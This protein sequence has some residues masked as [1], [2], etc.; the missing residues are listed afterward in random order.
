[1][2]QSS[3]TISL[4]PEVKGGPFVFW[5]DLEGACRDAAALG[6]AAVEIFLPSPSAISPAVLGQVLS[7]HN[8]ELA[9]LGTG[10]GWAVHKLHLTHPSAEI[11]V[12]AREFIKGMVR[13][14]SEFGAP[15]IVGSMQGRHGDG[16]SSE[17]ARSWLREAL[18]ELGKEAEA[19]SVFLLFEPLNRY[20]T[21]LLTQT[22]DAVQLL[23]SL[24]SPNVKILCDLFHMNIEE[25]NIGRSLRVAGENLGHV[26]W[27]DSNR[28][29]AGFGHLD[30]REVAEALREMN[31]SGYLSA[32]ALPYP[33]S[34]AAAIRSLATLRTSFPEAQG[35][36]LARAPGTR[37]RTGVV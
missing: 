34:R 7:R 21:N 3:V 23:A 28:R 11:R 14:G 36:G 9:A 25:E 24:E 2:I 33:D 1:M 15:A 19:A 10:A 26:H 5:D 20:E 18:D 13:F 30:F 17:Q 27:V 4:V 22:A 6:Y 8:L 12:R 32:E 37:G 16:V 29:A 35:H 31:Y